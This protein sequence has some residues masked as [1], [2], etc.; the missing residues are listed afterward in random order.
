MRIPV[1]PTIIVAIAVG[2]MLALGGWQ[3]DRAHQKDAAVEVWRANMSLP[4][5]AYPTQNPADESYR[6]R[7]L[8]AQCVRVVNWQ[9]VGGRSKDGQTGWRHIAYCTTGAEGPGLV[10]D[11]GVSKRPDAS[12]T[13][14][15]GAVTGYATHEPDNSSMI[16][17]LTGRASP[18]RLMIVAETPAPG[19]SAS[20]SPDPE[21]VPNN[22]RSYMV[23]WFL[24]AAIAVIIYGLALHK[25]QRTE[26]PRD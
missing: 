9:V 2:I 26:Q 23:Q 5:T 12:V 1:I 19:L 25:R 11:M 20:A 16:E 4:V 13:W 21:S 10:V 15:G 18:P 8:S 22:H 6:F 7:R 24:F 17:R 3:L 14:Q